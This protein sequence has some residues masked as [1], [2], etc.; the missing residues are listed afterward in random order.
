MAYV[1]GFILPVP[2]K[3]I[4]AY[5]SRPGYQRFVNY[6]ESKRPGEVIRLH[7]VRDGKRLTVP[8]TLQERPSRE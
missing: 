4:A 7:I 2:R 8:V 3:K 6:V 1:D 5:R